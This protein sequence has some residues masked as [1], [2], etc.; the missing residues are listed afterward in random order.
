ML[1]HYSLSGGHAQAALDGFG[2]HRLL[3]T[4][5]RAESVN[6]AGEGMEAFR[7]G[8]EQGYKRGSQH[9]RHVLQGH[10]P[11]EDRASN[12]LLRRFSYWYRVIS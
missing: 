1:C 2:L 10:R 12:R 6:I 11:K 7:S 3:W 8:L 4:E 9:A 5:D